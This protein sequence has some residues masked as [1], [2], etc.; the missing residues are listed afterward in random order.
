M[1]AAAVLII[2]YWGQAICRRMIYIFNAWALIMTLMH[3]HFNRSYVV[4]QNLRVRSCPKWNILRSLCRQF[5]GGE[6]ATHVVTVCPYAQKIG[7][8]GV[9]R[10][11]YISKHFSAFQNE[12]AAR[13]WSQAH[14]SCTRS[15]NSTFSLLDV[16]EDS[17]YSDCTTAVGSSIKTTPSAY[18]LTSKCRSPYFI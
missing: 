10:L 15:G 5:E 14:R 9:S 7:K 8:W 16:W 2:G 3:G 13:D 12:P 11:I 17:G 6:A 4:N 18:R 1:R